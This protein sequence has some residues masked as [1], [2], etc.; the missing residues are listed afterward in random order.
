MESGMGYSP[1]LNTTIYKKLTK[2]KKNKLANPIKI[3]LERFRPLDEDI[4]H[5][6]SQSEM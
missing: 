5:L 4:H 6:N 3:D 1:V 2:A